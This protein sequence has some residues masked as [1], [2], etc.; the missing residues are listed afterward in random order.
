VSF[1]DRTALTG[2]QKLDCFALGA[3]LAVLNLTV[4][5]FWTLTSCNPHHGAVCDGGWTLFD[6]LALAL[7]IASIAGMI[8][9][10]VRLM[11]V[12]ENND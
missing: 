8:A 4:L 10:I 2:K 3:G 11:R 7:P 6:Y 12:E 1:S 9:L 5:V